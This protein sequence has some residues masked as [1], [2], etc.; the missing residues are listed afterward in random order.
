MAIRDIFMINKTIFSH[1][2]SSISTVHIVSLSV[3]LEYLGLTSGISSLIDAKRFL[4][5]ML[6]I[7]IAACAFSELSGIDATNPWQL[8]LKLV[9]D[10]ATLI[11]G[12]LFIFTI[13]HL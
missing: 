12:I 8:L 1:S 5:L 9:F 6:I 3:G 11:L 4:K 13:F 7:W 2:D 10:V